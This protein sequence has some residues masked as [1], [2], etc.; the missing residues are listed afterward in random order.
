MSP[1]PDFYVGLVDQSLELA[2]QAVYCMRHFVRSTT[3]IDNKTHHFSQLEV[4]N[5][6][7]FSIFQNILDVCI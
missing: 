1:H 3:L 6:A 7:G 4:Y 2:R 5:S